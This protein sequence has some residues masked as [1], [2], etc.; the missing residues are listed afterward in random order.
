VKQGIDYQETFSPIISTSALRSLFALAAMKKY[1]V[2]TFDIK[3]A[4]L[5]GNVE[6]NLYMYPP[7]GYNFKGKV[8]KLKKVLYG[9]KQTPLRWNIRFTNF[10]REKNFELL[11][12]E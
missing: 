4:F 9:L 12:S 11:K 6:E 1:K 7:E 3:T 10:L 2:V 8:F 5:Y